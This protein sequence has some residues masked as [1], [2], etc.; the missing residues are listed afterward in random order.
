MAAV[1]PPGAG[2]SLQDLFAAVL[3]SAGLRILRVRRRPRGSVEYDLVDP[4]GGRKFVLTVQLSRLRT[5]PSG[6]GIAAFIRAPGLRRDR[7]RTSALVANE[8]AQNL[9]VGWTAPR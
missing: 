7:S 3:E 4:W 6:L 8:P 2:G 9:D 5:L 1:N